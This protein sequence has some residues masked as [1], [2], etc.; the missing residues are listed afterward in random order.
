[1]IESKK[2][3]PFVLFVTNDHE[4]E[5][6]ISP[7]FQ[8]YGDYFSTQNSAVALEI[9][10]HQRVD[11]LLIDES[12]YQ[13]KTIASKYRKNIFDLYKKAIEK[14]A[15]VIT[16]VL[17]SKRNSNFIN[18]FPRKSEVLIKLDRNNIDENKIRYLL[19]TFSRQKYRSVVLKDI[20][21]GSKIPVPL[22][23][24]DD[25]NTAFELFL[26]ENVIFS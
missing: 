16:L 22:F 14:N 8:D 24:Q 9:F 3:V 4:L 10:E 11:V 18:E 26:V 15:K 6:K 20:K 25:E 5:R 21:L 19:L 23:V 1:M 12:L 2:W 13:D 7:A 17:F